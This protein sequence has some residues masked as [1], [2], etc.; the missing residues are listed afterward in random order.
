M[1]DAGRSFESVDPTLHSEVAMLRA[2]RTA[3]AARTVRAVGAA[4]AATAV[5]SVRLVRAVRRV[6]ADRSVRTPRLARRFVLSLAALTL[7]V[8]V[9]AGSAHAAVPAPARGIDFGACPALSELPEG[10]D[11]GAWRCEAMTASGHMTLGRLDQ[12]LGRGMAITFAE[13]TV[14]GQVRQV[15]G[16]MTAAPVRVRGIPLVITPRYA[17]YFDFQSNDQ[18][19]GE[20]NLTFA[21]SGPAVPPGCSIGT[22]ADPVRLVLK[23]TAASTVVSQDPLVLAFGVADNRFTAP[24]TSGCGRLGPVL[25]AVLRMPSPAG[26]NSLALNAR[27]GLRGYGEAGAP[28]SRAGG[29]ISRSG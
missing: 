15:F 6:H 13:G 14:D 19:R 8:G 12:S 2:A 10:A 17:G 29:L 22:D 20:L 25:D 27:V 9:T 3:H 7:G 24:R 26:A 1:L 21:I 18:R 11:P 16:A 4:T 5:R 28:A 23:E